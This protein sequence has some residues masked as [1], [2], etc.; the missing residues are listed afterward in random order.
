[1]SLLKKKK[2]IITVGFV[3]SIVGLEGTLVGFLFLV[4]VE[5]TT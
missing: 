4:G 2:L 1:M 5:N 3:I